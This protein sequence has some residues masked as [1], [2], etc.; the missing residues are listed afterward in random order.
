[1][2]F[3]S[4]SFHNGSV[5]TCFYCEMD[6]ECLNT[7]KNSIMDNIFFYPLRSPFTGVVRQWK[8]TFI[9][10]EAEDLELFI[11]QGNLTFLYKA[12]QG[13]LCF[14]IS[15]R[16]LVRQFFCYSTAIIL[17]EDLLNQNWTWSVSTI[18]ETIETVLFPQVPWE[19]SGKP[20]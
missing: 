19:S 4:G 20:S 13:C 14:V 16:H 17:L 5:W 7:R 12:S 2:F 15:E 3:Q 8:D 9:S 6:S 1:M 18:S 10:M 11:G